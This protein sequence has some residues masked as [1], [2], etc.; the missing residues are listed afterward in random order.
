[1]RLRLGAFAEE[2]DNQFAILVKKLH[3]VMP[4]RFT[5]QPLLKTVSRKCK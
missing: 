4:A 1:L 3:R 2:A 5:I